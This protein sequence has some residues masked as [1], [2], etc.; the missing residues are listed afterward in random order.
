MKIFIYNIVICL[1]FSTNIYAAD[2]LIDPNL[3]NG[4][5]AENVIL[6]E[7]MSVGMIGYLDTSEN[8]VKIAKKASTD[9]IECG[10]T[11]NIFSIEDG[12]SLTSA[13]YL[14]NNN[15]LVTFADTTSTFIRSYMIKNTNF[16]IST[17]DYPIHWSASSNTYPSVVRFEL[18]KALFLINASTYCAASTADVSRTTPTVATPTSILADAPTYATGVCVD[19]NVVIILGRSNVAPNPIVANRVANLSYTRTT[20]AITGFESASSEQID[21]DYVENN[22]VL[23]TYRYGGG[24]PYIIKALL[25][26]DVNGTPTVGSP[27][28]GFPNESAD[29]ISTCYLGGGISLTTYYDTATGYIYSIPITGLD[30]ASPTVGS[31]ITTSYSCLLSAGVKSPNIVNLGN[32]SVLVLYVNNSY[33]LRGFIISNINTSP[34]VSP[35]ITKF[36]DIYAQRILGVNIGNNRIMMFVEDRS[37]TSSRLK[38][39][40]MNNIL[41]VSESSPTPT[42]ATKYMICQSGTSSSTVLAQRL[43]TDKYIRFSSPIPSIT[44]GEFRSCVGGDY[45]NILLPDAPPTPIIQNPYSSVKLGI[46]TGSGHL[47][48]KDQ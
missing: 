28:S 26:S 10:F 12:A 17:T 43:Y 18:D 36:P 39:F 32:Y 45:M 19:T 24:S 3:I 47:I 34:I 6:G 41:P 38:M 13:K 27:L 37:N 35:L 8:T 46:S 44:F 22:K 42:Y 1:L 21:A 7:S 14:G 33:Q 29:N 9:T 23:V 16:P 5:T 11:Q 15:V 31:T 25:I 30:G 20:S 4:Y 40:V 48:L 2:N